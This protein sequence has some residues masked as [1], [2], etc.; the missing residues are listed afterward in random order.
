MKIPDE[1]LKEFKEIWKKQYN[2]EI[3]DAKAL[4]SASNLLG[5]YELLLKGKWEEE[6][7]QR[8]LIKEPKGFHMIGI[9]YTCCICGA[10]VSNEETW[11]DA[12]GIKCLTCQGS[13]DRKEIPESVCKDDRSWY[14]MYQLQ[15]KFG[16]HP[17]TARKMART[18]DSRHI[19]LRMTVAFLTA[20][21][22]QLLKILD[23]KLIFSEQLLIN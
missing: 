15:S 23:Y 1:A 13:L 3:S 21:F 10:H 2:E 20:T 19:L 17:A 18:G 14:A 9:G 11:Y 22:F 7:R 5:L 6:E 12:N 4:E 8:R 16:I